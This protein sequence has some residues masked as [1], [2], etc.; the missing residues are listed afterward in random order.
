MTEPSEAAIRAALRAADIDDPVRAEVER[1]REM[2]R[3]AYLVDRCGA[4][5]AS[6]QEALNSGDGTY[7]P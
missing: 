5:P 2:L 7:R 4:L 1:V 6:V 3:A